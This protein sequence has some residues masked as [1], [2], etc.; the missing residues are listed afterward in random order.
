MIWKEGVYIFRPDMRTLMCAQSWF[1]FR[2]TDEARTLRCITAVSIGMIN[3]RTVCNTNRNRFP[4]RPLSPESCLRWVRIPV[5]VPPWLLRCRSTRSSTPRH[6]TER[7]GRS[8]LQ[9]VHGG[10]WFSGLVQD[11][12]RRGSL[13]RPERVDNRT[14]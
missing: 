14:N 13:S 3:V 7:V 10:G 11:L 2:L 12:S 5:R 4:C 9:W 1:D 8:P 6:V